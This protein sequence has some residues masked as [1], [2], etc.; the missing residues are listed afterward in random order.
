MEALHARADG[1][2]DAG[3]VDAENGWQRVLRV[4][5]GPTADL[6]VERVKAGSVNANQHLARLGRGAG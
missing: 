2:D 1:F 3:K 4:R 6:G 5:C